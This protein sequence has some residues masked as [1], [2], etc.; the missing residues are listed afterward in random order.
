MDFLNQIFNLNKVNKSSEIKEF[1]KL[2]TDRLILRKVDISDLLSIH[3]IF[4][5]PNVQRFQSIKHYSIETMKKYIY[6][7]E[8][9]YSRGYK[10][11]WGIQDKSTKKLIGNLM[12]YL[13]KGDFVE[14]QSDLLPPFW[15]KG[16]TKEAYKEVFKYLKMQRKKGVYAKINVDNIGILGV[17]NSCGF[18]LTNIQQMRPFEYAAE[19]ILDF[20]NPY[21]NSELIVESNNNINKSLYYVMFNLFNAKKIASF[22]EDGVTMCIFASTKIMREFVIVDD[23]V[24]V[25]GSNPQTHVTLECSIGSIYSYLLNRCKEKLY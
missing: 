8:N 10:V 19:F 11:F 14:I 22:S 15:N 17:M 2:E 1:P 3:Q 6:E 9:D 20:E 23:N 5:D 16:L 7:L 24:I 13:D 25:H 21:T 18:K 12:V 4:N